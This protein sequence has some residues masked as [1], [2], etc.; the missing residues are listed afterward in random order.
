MKHFKIKGVLQ[1]IIVIPILVVLLSF[2]VPN[3]TRA[4]ASEAV[5]TFGGML[6]G[7]IVEFVAGIFD[8]ILFGLDGMF[9]Q[10]RTGLETAVDVVSGVASYINPFDR[11]ALPAASD[12]SKYY[13][14]IDGDVQD[15]IEYDDE[16]DRGILQHF[17]NPD[18]YSVPA[19]RLSPKEIFANEVPALD[20]NFIHPKYND[21]QYDSEESFR[22]KSV[23]SQL[24][25]TIATWYVSLRN[26]AIIGLLSILLYVGI[27]IM[28]SSLAA[29]KAKYKQMF[30][31]WLIALC[32]IFFLHYIMSFALTITDAITDA[33]AS[34][35]TDV[36]VYVLDG[37]KEDGIPGDY[38]TNYQTAFSTNLTGLARFRVQYKSMGARWF[39]LLM[40]IA[41]VILTVMFLYTYVKRV[42]MMAFLTLIAPLVC[43]TY[44]IDKIGDGKAQAFNMWLKEFV[45]NALIQPFHLLLY[46]IFIG[47]AMNLA[48]KNWFYSIVCLVFIFEAEKI[49]KKMFGFEKGG[50]GTIGTLGGFA[51]GALAAKAVSKLGNISGG[52]S[53]GSGGASTPAI[54]SSKNKTKSTD[55]GA[56][57][58]QLPEPTVEP[59]V[60]QQQEQQVSPENHQEETNE[61]R[62]R[63][64]Q[65]QNGVNAELE[66][67][68]REQRPEI[69]A[70]NVQGIR[71]NENPEQVPQEDYSAENRALEDENL[72]IWKDKATGVHMQTDRNGYFKDSLSGIHSIAQSKVRGKNHKAVIKGAAKGAAKAYVRGGMALAG[73][74]IGAAAGI[75][76]GDLDNVFKM[77][78]AGFAAGNAG[79]KAIPGAIGNKVA[80]GK[81]R[82]QN[83][84]QK[85]YLEGI[86]G[87]KGAKTIMGRQEFFNNQENWDYFREEFK[88][89][90]GSYKTEKELKGIMANAYDYTEKGINDLDDIKA[91]IELEEAK[92]QQEY[93]RIEQQYQGEENKDQRVA[94]KREANKKARQQAIF[95]TQWYKTRMNPSDLGD[96]KKMKDRESYLAEE[97]KQRGVSTQQANQ[98]A[99]SVMDDIRILYRG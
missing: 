38:K 28:L 66:P 25:E 61:T 23:A 60:K 34:G 99:K 29:E 73:A 76:T 33:I 39:N 89:D 52:K 8:A 37:N 49:L 64:R 44:P 26:L 9:I 51:G 30:L 85:P 35:V 7:P 47:S 18:N 83:S 11:D 24:H 91:G 69:E 72:K 88:N 22:E 90:D 53:K 45:F 74:T 15:I 56:Y 43:L 78:V 59:E 79:G 77:G 94:A 27:R 97:F 1:K 19:I 31:D 46:A 92:K 98:Q 80:A 4:S 12:T 48:A 40:Y 21:A 68:E 20:V 96:V 50:L 54:A 82:F 17:V 42:I 81:K 32:L 58:G 86:Y 41:L 75:A 62:N 71:L 70:E 55:F 93:R 65:F 67:V 63:N 16:I 95:A 84:I 10:D 6:T 36:N 3:Y 87:K 57:D 14:P 13:G 5:S 2:S